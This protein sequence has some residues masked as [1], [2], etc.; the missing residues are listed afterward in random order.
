MN[1]SG[2][3]RPT[4]P[5]PCGARF[6]LIPALPRLPPPPSAFYQNAAART[7]AADLGGKQ[8]N[9]ENKARLRHTRGRRMGVPALMPATHKPDP[10][11]GG[12]VLP[13]RSGPRGRRRGRAPNDEASR[14][15][16]AGPLEGRPPLSPSPRGDPQRGPGP[17]RLKSLLL[18]GVRALAYARRPAVGETPS[19]PPVSTPSSGL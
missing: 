17:C 14:R 9:I 11:C 15:A 18:R 7:P 10:G 3:R 16:E 4:H 1:S 12:P 5:V 6:P 8:K 2:H 13:V 19:F